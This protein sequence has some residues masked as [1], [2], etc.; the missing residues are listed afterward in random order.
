M[1]TSFFLYANELFSSSYLRAWFFSFSFCFFR[2]CCSCSRDLI[3]IHRS[4]HTPANLHKF[5]RIYSQILNANSSALFA[6]HVPRATPLSITELISTDANCLSACRQLFGLNSDFWLVGVVYFANYELRTE[7]LTRNA[8]GVNGFSIYKG[9]KG[10]IVRC[11]S[12]SD[13]DLQILFQVRKNVHLSNQFT[14]KLK[15]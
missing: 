4:Q 2:G 5:L 11:Q 12:A 14:F 13:L 7:L 6:N 1:R 15:I 8:L 10:G 9:D 3:A